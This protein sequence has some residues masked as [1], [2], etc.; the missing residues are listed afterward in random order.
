[1]NR[2]TI[3]TKTGK[4]LLETTGKTNDLSRDLRNILKEI[5]GKV[6]VSK[7]LDRL[8]RYTVPKLLEVLGSLEK[9][10]YVREFVAQQDAPAPARAA[11]SQP[12]SSPPSAPGGDDDLDFSSLVS[13]PV[14]APAS[15][16]RPNSTTDEIS[17]QAVVTRARVAA[18]RAKSADGAA[19][20]KA[21]KAKDTGEDPARR[22]A[23]EKLKREAEERVRREVGEFTRRDSEERARKEA[24]EKVRHA[25]EERFRRE[26]EEKARRENEL[27]AKRESEERKWKDAEDRVRRDA[28]TKARKEAE[29]KLRRETEE[30]SRRD[31]DDRRRREEED[32]IRQEREHAERLIHIEAE[33]KAKVETEMRTRREV[34]ERLRREEEDRP[35]REAEERAR[36]EEEE[37]RRWEE[38]EER[39][40]REAE[41]LVHRKEVEIRS[42]KAA[43]ER[44]RKEEEDRHAHAALERSLREQ[45]E[46]A[47]REAAVKTREQEE[48][49]RQEREVRA[50]W[51]ARQAEIAAQEE[52]REMEKQR[53]RD[54]ENKA[55]EEAEKL[56]KAEA[57]AEARARKDALAKEKAEEY[58]RRKQEAKE[59][60]VDVS[61][62]SLPAREAW[63]KRQ[64]RSLARP[65]T[66]GAGILLVAAV[67]LVYVM[68]IDT[69]PYEKAGQAWLGEPVKIGSISMSLVPLPQL[70]FEKVAIGREPPMRIA[71]IRGSPEIGSFFGDKKVLKSIELEG[72][73]QS[74]E[75]LAVLISDKGKGESLGIERVT[76][77]GLKL[78]PP[79]LDLPPLDLEA[80]LTLDGALRTVTLTNTERKISVTLQPQGDRAGI[81]I[82]ADTLPLPAGTDLLVGNFSAKGTLTATGLDL[83]ELDGRALDGTFKG[84]ARLRWPDGWTLDGDIAVRQ[85]EAARIAAPLIKTGTLEGKVQFG[86]RAPT[87][88]KLFASTRLDGHFTVQKGSIT[89]IDMTRVLQG[90][91]TGGGTTLF[92]ELNGSVHADPGRVQVRQ[93]RMVAGLL[94]ATGEVDMDPDKKLSGRLQIELRAQTTQA[95]ASISVSGTL[96]DPQFRRGL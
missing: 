3:F 80:T 29:E 56:A 49:E 62:L 25:A 63:A 7:L 8:D 53:A 28:E 37:R 95:R 11:I 9:D 24:E 10:G 94:N 92:P 15:P 68:P 74:R 26:A 16:A 70:K 58:A 42:R 78:G 21:E 93:I 12:P 14:P 65:F 96:K 69:A 6:S 90:S 60:G 50:R 27:K 44:I 5:D 17:R 64:D 18:A 59:R 85:M 32:R 48:R 86:M 33:A 75:L 82:S 19:K 41:E 57:D 43:E 2:R 20:P 84:S 76:A 35:R 38:E 89:N 4:G 51:E 47:R 71:V 55:R 72:V 45:E 66:V 61:E 88:D 36:R 67:V 79:E 87:P 91:S 30:R 77:R 81:E 39:R 1:M 13:T 73:T 52:S 54:E 40:K 23:D 83:R 31:E 22:E 46:K 34:E